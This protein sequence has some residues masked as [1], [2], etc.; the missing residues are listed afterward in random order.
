[1]LICSI[2]E[3]FLDSAVFVVQRLAALTQVLLNVIPD[4]N[5]EEQPQMD[6]FSAEGVRHNT[7]LLI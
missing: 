4:A 7:A 6:V 1:M 5:R 2:I 3:S